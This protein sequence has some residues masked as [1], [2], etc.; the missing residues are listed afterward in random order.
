MY[1]ATAVLAWT[2]SRAMSFVGE[3]A[4]GDVDDDGRCE[5]G[6]RAEDVDDAEDAGSCGYRD[7]G[8]PI[9]SF[10]KSSSREMRALDRGSVLASSTDSDASSK[11]STV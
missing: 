2:I 3:L 9:A 5:A 8:S 4:G 10:W 11:D 1:S 7:A 6:G